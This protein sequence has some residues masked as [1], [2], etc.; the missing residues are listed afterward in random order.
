MYSIKTMIKI[1]Q[2]LKRYTVMMFVMGIIVIML[3]EGGF[4]VQLLGNLSNSYNRN[5]GEKNSPKSAYSTLFY[6]NGNGSGWT[7]LTKSGS[8]TYISSTS[9]NFS[10]PASNVEWVYSYLDNAPRTFQSISPNTVY[11]VN[12]PL[13][14][15]VMGSRFGI[16]VFASDNEYYQYYLDYSSAK[17][18]IFLN[19]DL[20]DLYNKTLT[21]Y[22]QMFLQTTYINGNLS[23]AYSYDLTNWTYSNTSLTPFFTPSY[24]GL[25]ADDGGFFTAASYSFNDFATI[26]APDAPTNVQALFLPGSGQAVISWTPPSG[27]ITHYDLFRSTASGQEVEIRS[28]GSSSPY[29]DTGLTNGVT[30]YY[31]IAA[32]N[33]E[34]V[35]P[36]S[37]EVPTTSV[38][39]PTAPPA[40]QATAGRQSVYLNWTTPL[41]DGGSSITGYQINRSSSPGTETPYQ[42]IGVS[43]SFNDTGLVSPTTYYYTVAAINANGNGANSSEVSAQP[44]TLASAPQSLGATGVQLDTINLTWIAPASPGNT[45]I[46]NYAIYRGTS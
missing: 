30:Y 4:W 26:T 46:T 27:S 13:N 31:Q 15:S 16:S 19:A 12:I 6:A 25:F 8:Y 2:G 38:N 42:T 28:I 29:T 37:T 18:H 7:V 33:T 23:F 3:I 21:A 14:P 40:I 11:R 34:G 44:L 43:N 20:T 22:T 36:L 32:E 17:H 1:G 41:S 5:F 9:F 45:P 24:I 35:S 39:T 10:L